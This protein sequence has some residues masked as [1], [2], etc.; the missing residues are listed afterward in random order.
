MNETICLIYIGPTADSNPLERLSMQS[1]GLMV[2]VT[3][4]YELRICSVPIGTTV[5]TN[6][7]DCE[8][9]LVSTVLPM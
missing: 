5:N 7:L 2:K 3:V 6:P 4:S 8:H 1:C 9:T